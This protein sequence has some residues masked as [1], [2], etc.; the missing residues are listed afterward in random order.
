MENPKKI[1]GKVSSVINSP[2]KDYFNPNLSS[3]GV[4][5]QAIDPAYLPLNRSDKS[6]VLAKLENDVLISNM[7]MAEIDC[8]ITINIPA[9]F[10]IEATSCNEW[11]IPQVILK[12]NQL[13][14]LFINVGTLSVLIRDKDLIANIWAVPIYKINWNVI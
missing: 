8:G 11:L 2:A 6:F 10:K 5:V 13:K 1:K 12:N 7:G 9:N 3:I 14:L 4:S